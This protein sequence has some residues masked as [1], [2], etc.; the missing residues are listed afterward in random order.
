MHLTHSATYPAS[1]PNYLTSYLLSHMYINRC[2]LTLQLPSHCQ[3]TDRT[4][5][6]CAGLKRAQCR[7]VASLQWNRRQCP[8]AEDWTG[9]LEPSLS[10]AGRGTCAVVV[11]WKHHWRKADIGCGSSGEI[12]WCHRNWV[13][14][15]A[16]QWAD[17]KFELALKLTIWILTF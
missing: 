9:T 1:L 11:P 7:S 3:G 13:I 6:E 2:T 16:D 4:W 8:P 12:H 14:E 5:M 17:L 10:A 15:R